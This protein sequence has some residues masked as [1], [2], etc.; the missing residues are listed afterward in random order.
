MRKRYRDRLRSVNG[1]EILLISG[2][3]LKCLNC[4]SSC[5]LT[6][7]PE[8]QTLEILELRE[9][10]C[11]LKIELKK[12]KMRRSEIGAEVLQSRDQNHK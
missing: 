6:Q 10:V 4:V 12:G 3:I 9:L 5:Y 7:T 8:D 2:L 1:V 11:E